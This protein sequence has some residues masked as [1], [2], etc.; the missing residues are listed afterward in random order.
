LLQPARRQLPLAAL[1]NLSTD[2]AAVPTEI[3][4]LLQQAIAVRLTEAR[5]AYL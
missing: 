3:A 2:A 1:N 4:F 5:R